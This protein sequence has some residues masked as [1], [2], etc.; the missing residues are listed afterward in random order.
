MRKE[1]L[2]NIL[3]VKL[4]GSTVENRALNY[5]TVGLHCIY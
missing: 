1:S 3:E 4:R 5:A 2:A